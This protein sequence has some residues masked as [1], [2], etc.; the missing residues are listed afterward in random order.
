MRALRAG[1]ERERASHGCFCLGL[2]LAA[3]ASDFQRIHLA[4]KERPVR[5]KS[6]SKSLCQLVKENKGSCF[7]GFFYL[8][9][10]IKGPCIIS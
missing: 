9:P 2:W 3:N 4:T 7:M 1:T 6:L 8:S 5:W 10:L